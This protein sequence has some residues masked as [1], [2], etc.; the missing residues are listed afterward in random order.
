MENVNN[1]SNIDDIVKSDDIEWQIAS[2]WISL[3][4][5]TPPSVFPV[6]SKKAKQNRQKLSDIETHSVT[7]F[8]FISTSKGGRHLV[9]DN[10]T[11]RLSLHKVTGLSYWVCSIPSCTAWCMLD[12]Q[13]KR[14]IQSYRDHNHEVGISQRDF[15]NFISAL[16]N[17]VKENPHVKPKV[18]YDIEVEKIRQHWRDNNLKNRTNRIKEF[19]PSFEAVHAAMLNTRNAVLSA[20]SLR[21]TGDETAITEAP[22]PSPS[23]FTRSKDTKTNKKH[24]STLSLLSSSLDL[25]N[26]VS[27]TSKATEFVSF[28]FPAYGT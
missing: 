24:R 5:S 10:Q 9:V 12:A 23:K 19:L 25:D 20:V 11:F 3:P 21:A 28:M 7:S 2:D 27:R 6:K 8:N 4:A 15:K 1:S 18:I 26:M 14:I 13:E 16:K 17:A 22:Y